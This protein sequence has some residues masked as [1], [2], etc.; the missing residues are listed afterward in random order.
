MV[1][2]IVVTYILVKPDDRLQPDSRSIYQQQPYN[3]IVRRKP[4]EK[5]IIGRAKCEE[6]VDNINDLKLLK[7]ITDKRKL[8]AYES[9]VLFKNRNSS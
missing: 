1:P 9:I 4:H 7:S 8:D 5:Q 6:L 2:E 3:T